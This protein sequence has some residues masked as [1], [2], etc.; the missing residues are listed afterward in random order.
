MDSK[1][2]VL[3]IGHGRGGT[4]AVMGYL[5]LYPEINMAFEENQM[6]LQDDNPKVYTGDDKFNWGSELSQRQ[7]SKNYNGNK[8]ALGPYNISANR[9]VECVEKKSVILHDN[10]EKLYVVFVSRKSEDTIAS[11][12]S[13]KLDA[14]E[15]WAK[16]N[17]Q[18]NESEILWLKGY[19]MDHFE[20]DFYDFLQEDS[21]KRSL[22]DYLGIKF[23]KGFSNKEVETIGY[24]TKKLS[25]DNVLHRPV[26]KTIQP[27]EKKVIKKSSVKKSVMKKP[28]SK[29]KVV[30]KKRTIKKK[31]D[32]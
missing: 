1:K 13:R 22:C 18:N 4:S 25:I 5:N 21:V 11:I 6:I 19:F 8:I 7:L 15:K 30:S 20:L 32:E 12:I 10:F 16:N 29:K 27:E 2:F 3:L 31:K 14:T 24:G 23:N 9:I 17:W 28:Y 26:T